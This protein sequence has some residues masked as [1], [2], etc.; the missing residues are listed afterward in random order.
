MLRHSVIAYRNDAPD[1]L[2]RIS[3]AG[4]AWLRYVP[5]RM[6][7]T[8]RVQE[9]LPQGKAAVLINQSHTYRDIYMPIDP[10]EARLFDSIDGARSVGDIVAKAL[11]QSPETSRLDMVRAFFERLWWHDQVA[12][13]ISAA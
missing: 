12:F 8:L 13:D 4:D 1:S 11:P 3:L 6:P 2:K 9:R 10:T 7:D 5:I